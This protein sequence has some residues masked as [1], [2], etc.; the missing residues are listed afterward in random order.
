MKILLQSARFV[1]KLVG[2]EKNGGLR[3]KIFCR[4]EGVEIFAEWGSV[5]AERERRNTV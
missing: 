5:D 1:V 4:M 2:A 3:R